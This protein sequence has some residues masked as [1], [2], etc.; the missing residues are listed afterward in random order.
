MSNLNGKNG[1][2]KLHSY[3]RSE[4]ENKN[5]TNSQQVETGKQRWWNLGN[6]T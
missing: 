2:Y 1:F 3:V 6:H 4:N 5:L